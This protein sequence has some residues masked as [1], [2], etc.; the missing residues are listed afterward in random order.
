MACFRKFFVKI[1]KFFFPEKIPEFAA[2]MYIALAKNNR[3]SF[4]ADVSAEILE[5]I[6]ARNDIKNLLDIGTGPGFM[7]IEIAKGRSDLCLVGIDLSKKLIE[8]A[9]KEANKQGCHIIF[10]IGD[11][12]HLKFQ[13]NAFDFVISSGELNSLKDSSAAIKEWLRVLR[14]GGEIWI[15]DPTVLV[16]RD[17]AED[18]SRLKKILD[19]MEKDLATRKDR[20]FF[21][22]LRQI[23]DLPPKPF[24]LDEITKIMKNVFGSYQCG[25]FARKGYTKIELIK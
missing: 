21:R 9:I 6:N 10:E 8:A 5:R 20:F 19:G 15:Y 16:D 23:S 11:A 24:P 25:V 1:I 17:D 14:P 2:W 7:L 18:I 3:T 4:Y 13:D 22:L 12:N